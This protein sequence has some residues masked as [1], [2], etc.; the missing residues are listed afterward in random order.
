[1]KAPGSGYFGQWIN[2]IY[3]V[4]AYLYECDQLND[5]TALTMTDE[6]WTDRR[7]HTFVLGNDRITAVLSNFGY[8]R[9][10]QDEGCA[11]FLNDYNPP[12]FQ[13]GGGF[14]YLKYDGGYLSTYF[15]GSKMTREFGAGYMRK[16]KSNESSTVEEVV[17][18]PYGDDPVLIK[19]VR[20]I[21]LSR[22]AKNYSWFEYLAS[23]MYQMTFTHYCLAQLT[24][25]T[26]NVNRFRRQFD[27]SFKKTIKKFPGGV[28]CSRKYERESL[29]LKLSHSV[30]QGIFRAMGKRFYNN[31]NNSGVDYLPPKVVFSSLSDNNTALLTN[32]RSF[33]GSGGAENP[34][35]FNGK[36]Y[37]NINDNVSM[38]MLRSDLTVEG[39]ESRELYYIYA[40]DAPGFSLDSILEK[41]R[42]CDKDSLLFETIS[43]W[44]NDRI[45]ITFPEDTFVDRELMWHNNY[46]RS[47]M[48]YNDYFSAHILSQG[49]HYQYLMGLQGAP[50]DQL[51]HSLSFIYTEP[52]IAREHIL[53]TLR[54]MSK[55]GELPYATHG[56][57]LMIAAGMVPSD[58]QLMLLSYVG[59][60]VLAT[61][62]YE[63]LKY[64]Y[65]TKLDRN[66]VRRTVLEGVMLAYKYAIEDIG[67]GEH[68]LMRMRTGDWNDQAVYGR[69]PLH[70]TAYAQK[71]GESMLNSTIACYSFRIFGDMLAAIGKTEDAEFSLAWAESM[72]KA[73]SAQ[74]T[75]E[76]FRRA[77]LGEKIGWL[78]EDLL[79][80]E[81]QPWAIITGAADGDMSAIL[82]ENIRKHLDNPNGA[83]LISHN[84][85]KSENSIGL[86]SG[87]LENGGIWPAINGYLVWALSKVNG[88]WA[89]EEWLKNMRTAQ[90]EA[91]PEIWYGIWSGPDSHNASYAKYP[92]RTQNSKNPYT[93][94]TE[95]RFKLTVG[96]DWEDF[97]VLNL[98]AHTWQQYSLLKILGLEFSANSINLKPVIPIEKYKITSALIDVERDGD[99]FTVSYRPLNRLS[100]SINF[101]YNN[102]MRS[103]KSEV[104]FEKIKFDFSK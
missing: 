83:S 77:Y 89:F 41:Y 57:G 6:A 21:N 102:S 49:G 12:A 92:G 7:N 58:L 104:P 61:R 85:Q 52:Q 46:L 1:M 16:V 48:S 53:F 95:K 15:N 36:L 97:P 27:K 50:R 39:G 98:H 31:K 60:Y 45:A 88:E 9:I 100:L 2:G 11:K 29:P 62:D 66:S 73:V 101:E 90:A 19:K 81:P 38:L 10:R 82:C 22:E 3:D 30:A 13:Y 35:Y 99:C 71:N 14:G 63:F 37:Q 87:V 47:S 5:K 103:L 33:F 78:G 26:A 75:G 44:K 93:G 18:A 67:L 34:D 69:V 20:I 64:E 32:A 59:E 4:P 70:L 79:W 76:W 94:E 72:K 96:V 54:E 42:N 86:D 91:Y 24:F 28:S 51:Q 25:N 17:F 74:W 80:L 56:H 84:P 8:F 40:Y 65:T 23:D 55:A 68:G 43:K